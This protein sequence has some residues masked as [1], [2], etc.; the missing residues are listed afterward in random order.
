MSRSGSCVEAQDGAASGSAV[1]LAACAPDLPSQRWLTERGGLVSGV[2]PLQCLWVAGGKV[3]APGT[4]TEIQPCSDAEEQRWGLRGEVRDHASTSCLE[5][6]AAVEEQLRLAACGG[7][8]RQTWTLW[9]PASDPAPVETDAGVEAEDAG[10][11]TD[12]SSGSVDGGGTDAS[13]GSVAP[14]GHGCGCS[15]GRDTPGLAVLVVGLLVLGLPV[16]SRR[17]RA[18]PAR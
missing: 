11:D 16:A 8:A 17:R 12:A 9:S 4:L 10:V 1:K 7:T 5:R 2:D 13:S 3:D 6:P 18:R 14:T 15:A